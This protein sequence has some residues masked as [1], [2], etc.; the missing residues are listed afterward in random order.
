ML[1]WTLAPA[2]SHISG[3]IMFLISIQGFFSLL[4][5]GHVAFVYSDIIANGCGAFIAI[6]D[7]P[8]SHILRLISREA[9]FQFSLKSFARLF[10]RCAVAW[11]TDNQTVQ[12]IVDSG[13]MKQD[14]HILA[15]DI[16]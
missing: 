3:I 15:V 14:L 6:D 7:M 16:F 13:S 2:K 4:F 12:L 8:V 9:T 11:F 10:S 5:A 1:S